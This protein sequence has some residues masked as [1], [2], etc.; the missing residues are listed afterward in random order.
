MFKG[1]IL[2]LLLL[3]STTVLANDYNYIVK[4]IDNSLVLIVDGEVFAT[5]NDFKLR[6]KEE[7][8]QILNGA[9]RSADLC[10][11]KGKWGSSV[12]D[13]AKHKINSAEHHIDQFHKMTKDTKVPQQYERSTEVI[14]TNHNDTKESVDQDL[15]EPTDFSPTEGLQ[16]QSQLI[17]EIIIVTPGQVKCDRCG[18]PINTETCTNISYPNG[19]Q[20]YIH[21]NGRCRPR[22]DKLEEVRERWL[23]KLK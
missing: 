2:S 17:Q 23:K 14:N 10:V 12:A 22:L 13:E 1:L 11:A 9:L 7:Q 15:T 20:F 6:P 5:I 8:L 18:H 19:D 3:A 16:E 4:Q 21:P